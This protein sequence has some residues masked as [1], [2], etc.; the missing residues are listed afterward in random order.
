[1]WHSA[2]IYIYIVHYIYLCVYIYFHPPLYLSLSLS[3]EALCAVTSRGDMRGSQSIQIGQIPSHSPSTSQYTQTARRGAL[4][5]VRG[6]HCL[7]C[8]YVFKMFQDFGMPQAPRMATSEDRRHKRHSTCMS[9]RVAGCHSPPSPGLRRNVLNAIIS[10]GPGWGP[11]I[12]RYPG[13]HLL[14][15]VVERH[16]QRPCTHV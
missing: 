7:R 16:F 9:S 11:H 12:V 4:S 13:I 8:S 5:S 2:Y 10:E 6:L 15:T 14:C 1:M 3:I